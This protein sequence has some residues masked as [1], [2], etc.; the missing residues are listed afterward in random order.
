MQRYQNTIQSQSGRALSG[1]TVTVRVM[2]ATPGAGALA[3]IYSDDGITPIGSS[4]VTTDSKGAFSFFAADGKY[5]LV[6][7]GTDI[8]QRILADVEVADVTERTSA[9]SSW[10]ADTILAG[11]VNKVR[12]V[13]GVKF[14]CSAAG[15]AAALTDLPATGGDVFITCEGAQSF[16]G[17]NPL[18]GIT[19]PFRLFFGQGT[20]TIPLLE[21]A[22]SASRQ[23]IRGAG[24][25]KTVLIPSAANQGVFRC[26]A[27]LTVA[28]PR[29]DDTIFADLTIRAHATGSNAANPAINTAGVRFG[30][31][32]VDFE[33]NGTGSFNRW[34]NLNALN[35]SYFNTVRVRMENQANVSGTVI[36]FVGN[37]VN[38]NDNANGNYIYPTIVGNTGTF[39]AI[40]ARAS[41][42]SNIINAALENNAS[43]TFLIPGTDTAI[44]GGHSEAWGTCITP[45][46]GADG[47]SN[48]VSFHGGD[49]SGT[50]TVNL[51]G[52]S[53]WRADNTNGLVFTNTGDTSVA[54]TGAT[55]NNSITAKN[56]T[57]LRFTMPTGAAG[58]IQ[59]ATGSNV[60]Q[61]NGGTAGGQILDSTGA[62]ARVSWTDAGVFTFTEQIVSSKATGTAP[63]SIASTTK[64]ANL[65]VDLLDGTDWTAPG[66]I[67]GVTPAAGT[68]TTLTANTSLSTALFGSA[69]NCSSSAAPAVCA[70]AP[71]GSVSIAVAATTVTVNTTA[72]TAN[73][74]IFI[75][76][77][78]SLGTKLGVTCNTSITRTYAVTARTA[79]TSFVITTSVAPVTNPACLSYLI[80]N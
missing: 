58:I 54:W 56:G 39:T 21:R 51:T 20:Y 26:S 36:A 40:D 79:A 67:G 25:K 78:S 17:T 43:A 35:L 10:T 59:A 75:M 45:T 74:Q 30:T 29:C 33:T 12:Y 14:A 47:A 3:T 52:F 24:Y 2:N 49:W 71:A 57:G 60:I 13:D 65:N 5:D 38:T 37:G 48:R 70:A 44:Y 16:A 77:D 80:V 31:F 4:A 76:E 72:V 64:V 53:G 8:T 50:C 23:E 55:F 1:V 7:T 22:A 15:V 11:V 18:T 61:I 6:I 32:D 46:T 42:Y 62:T 28:T 63:F 73:S 19:K 68:F 41:A 9:D 69:T 27:Y 34:I 66:A